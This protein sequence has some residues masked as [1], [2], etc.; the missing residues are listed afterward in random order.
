MKVTDS[1]D[2]GI[3]MGTSWGAEGLILSA[4]LRKGPGKA[5]FGCMKG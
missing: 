5:V 1:R 4:E 2:L 3:E